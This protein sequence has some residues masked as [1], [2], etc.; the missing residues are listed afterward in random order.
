MTAPLMALAIPL[1]DTALTIGRRFLRRQPIFNGDRGH[2]HHRL[3]K[4]GL[5]PRRVALLLYGMCGLAAGFSLLEQVAHAQFGGLI[6]IVFCAVAWI[7]IQHLGYLEFGTAARMLMEGAFRRLLSSQLTVRGVQDALTAASTTDE[8]WTAIRNAAKEFGF[9]EVEMSLAG[10]HYFERVAG[11][12]PGHAWRADI[13]I[14]EADGVI[15]TAEF[16]SEVQPATL[17][18]FAATIRQVLA[19]KVEALQN[20]QRVVALENAHGSPALSRSAEAGD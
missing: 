19:P 12:E 7:G 10:R 14:S 11:N 1:L 16:A 15:L 5:T 2:I 6:V 3:L 20:E 13:P 18:P 17:A 9:S 8:C 4:R